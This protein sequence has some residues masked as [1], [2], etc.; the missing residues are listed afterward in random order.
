[1]KLNF[2]KRRNSIAFFTTVK[3]NSFAFDLAKNFKDCDIHYFFNGPNTFYRWFTCNAPNNTKSI[4]NVT[5]EVNSLLHSYQIRNEKYRKDRISQF[6]EKY[7]IDF[8]GKLIA[9]DR[10]LGKGF[11]RG[12]ITRPDHFADKFTKNDSFFLV[13]FILNLESLFE[14]Y[15]IDNQPKFV[16]FHA[17]AGAPALL[18]SKICTNL[19]IPFFHFV[20]TRVSNRYC[21]DTDAQARLIYLERLFFQKKTSISKKSLNWAKNFIQNSQNAKYMPDYVLPDKSLLL[22][23]HLKNLF[24]SFLGFIYYIFMFEN[25]SYKFEQIKRQVYKISTSIK[26]FYLILFRT[27]DHVNNNQK[28]IYFPL[29]VDPESSTMIL[30]P[31]LTDQLWLIETLSKGMSADYILVVKEHKPM[32]GR[33]PLEYYRKLCALPRVI[34]VDPLTD[35]HALIKKSSLVCSI[36]GS[37]ILE[38]ILAKKAWLLLGDAP[39]KVIAM[40]HVWDGNIS[41]LSSY[42]NKAISDSSYPFKKILRYLSLIHQ[43]SFEMPSYL[44]WGNY[45]KISQNE[46]SLALRNIIKRIR[47]TISNNLFK[48]SSII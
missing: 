14:K 25:V 16:L 3:F 8:F 2:S 28:Y 13:D 42:I 5:A 43:N 46:K 27:Y 29:H 17:I 38:S 39:F 9:S 15:L 47:F 36:S 45:T 32:L 20:H 4:L 34:L 10:R 6:E 12:A 18:I 7:G 33:R 37:V 1:M 11:V 23:S 21:L 41:N 40:P 35:S 30:T 31:Y 26:A 19:K 22:L 24:L 44:L 48:S